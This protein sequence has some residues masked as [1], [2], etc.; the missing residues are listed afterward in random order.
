MKKRYKP[1]VV[2]SVLE[3]SAFPEEVSRFPKIA[4]DGVESRSGVS[5]TLVYDE[6][7]I[8]NTVSVGDC[9]FIY[10][11]AS[12]T[13]SI[14]FTIHSGGASTLLFFHVCNAGS[15]NFVETLPGS[16]V[17]QCRT[18]VFNSYALKIP[19]SSAV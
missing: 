19:D 17:L 6:E 2:A 12:V 10:V 7:V 18:C 4:R 11:S 16:R 3:E 1:F 15:F 8:H 13:I 14:I 5:E 9:C